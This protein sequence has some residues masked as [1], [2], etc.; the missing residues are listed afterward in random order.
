[1]S[2][3]ELGEE[4]KCIQTQGPV[5]EGVWRGGTERRQVERIWEDEGMK[6]GVRS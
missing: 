2:S 4:R 1:M 6:V 3:Y 5:W